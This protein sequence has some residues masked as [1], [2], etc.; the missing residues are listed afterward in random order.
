MYCLYFVFVVLALPYISKP[1][2]AKAEQPHIV[3]IFVDDL[4]WNDVEW[5]NPDIKMPVLS[6]LAADGVI[7][8]QSYT[9]PTCTPSRAAMMTGMY[10]FRTGNQ[11]QMIFNLHPSGV[12][13]EFKLL[14]EKLKEVGYFTHMVGKW[15]LGFCK[16]EYLPTSRGFDSHYGLW[17]LGVGHYDKM[18]GVLSPSE[19]Y[20]FRDNI[21]VVPKSD[22][23]LTLMLAERAEHIINGHYNKHPLF[24][25]FT[26][27]IPAKHLEIP[28]TFEALYCDIEDERTRKFYGKLSLMDHVIGRVVD[29]LKAR[30]MWDDTVLM[31]IGDNG[32]LAS[33][34]GSNYPFRGIAGTL[35]EGATRVPSLIHG[36]MLRE[37]GYVNNELW[38]LVDLHRT[39]L[40]L[41]GAESG[42]MC[43]LDG[44]NMWDTFSKGKK[45]PR[46]EH[47][48]NI[49][50]DPISPGAAIRIGD[51]KL[52]TGHPDLLYPYRDISLTDGWYNYGDPPASGLPS[53]DQEA[54]APPPLNVEY[55]FNVVVDPSEKNNIADQ[56]PDIVQ[57]LRDRLDE[58]RKLLIPPVN[59]TTELAGDAANYCGVWS[60]GWC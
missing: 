46:E 31:F 25:Q 8:N 52:I 10:P 57:N 30:E 51:Y 13:L 22:E 34:A 3:L 29:A 60:P 59:Q 16:E 12:P 54:N 20:D 56:H 15:H 26:M 32:A 43:E 53:T 4:G 58:H 9:H 47:V 5:H 55:L 36:S 18:N 33:Q 49:D 24:L 48:Y 17:T 14:P 45:S 40:A 37:T 19:G 23:Y 2:I 28:D 41:A 21:G 38:N 42:S 1:C 7:F 44:M 27:D 50:D 11:H 35:F 6:K 39:I